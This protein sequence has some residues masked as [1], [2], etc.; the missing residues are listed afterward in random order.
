MNSFVDKFRMQNLEARL[1]LRRLT[2]VNL[3]IELNA[4]LNMER[5]TA[6]T[7]LWE[8]SNREMHALESALERVKQAEECDR[9]AQ[10]DVAQRV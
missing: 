5:R 4:P 1:E 3:A 10:L 2:C 6:L 9:D 8:K 7:A